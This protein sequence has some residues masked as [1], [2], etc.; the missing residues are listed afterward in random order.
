MSRAAPMP[1]RAA[2]LLIVSLCLV[3]TSALAARHWLNTRGA[4]KKL[5]L[6]L[7][8]FA[9]DDILQPGEMRDVFV[10][11]ERFEACLTDAAE[12]NGG[13]V[14]ALHFTDAGEFTDV[15]IVMEVRAFWKDSIGAWARLACVGRAGLKDV[16]TSAHGYARADVEFYTDNGVALPDVETLR[17]VHADVAAA[18]C[19]LLT[20]LSFE[21]LRDREEE[22]SAEFIHVGPHRAVAP[23][24]LFVEE[25]EEQEDQEE[26]EEQEEGEGGAL[27]FIGESFER[28]SDGGI[29]TCFFHCRDHG[30]LDDEENGKSLDEL[31]ATR[32]AVLTAGATATEDAAATD[33]KAAQAAE[34]ALTVSGALGGLWEVGSEAE[35]ELQLLSFAAT[36]SLSPIQRVEAMLI[37]DTAERVRHALDCLREQQQNLH[38]IQL[39]LQ[40]GDW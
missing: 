3:P 9:L 39:T 7:L 16:R 32:R 19:R 20:Q 22:R 36:A 40:A 28:S 29:G 26:Q 12:A 5:E 24:G 18:R 27:L 8:P 25:E 35:A 14:G 31:I 21:E 30:E 11:E 10:F 17:A 33:A 4:G 37:T 13:C 15:S 6:G 38:E 1:P 23:F 34:A 2:I